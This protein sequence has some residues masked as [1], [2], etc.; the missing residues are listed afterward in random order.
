MCHTSGIPL[1]RAARAPRRVLQEPIHAEGQVRVLLQRGGVLDLV[2]V[3]DPEQ[4]FAI[5]VSREEPRI[6]SSAYAANVQIA[7]RA[8]RESGSDSHRHKLYPA[9]AGSTRNMA[10]PRGFEPR[11]P[12]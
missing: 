10:S 5:V 12:P 11:L 7:G 1:R 2:G 8:R 4:E 6:K 9:S 3:L